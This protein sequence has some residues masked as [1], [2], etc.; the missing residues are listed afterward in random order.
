VGGSWVEKSRFSNSGERL[1]ANPCGFMPTRAGFGR[2][3]TL[4]VEMSKSVSIAA[5]ADAEED[6]DDHHPSSGIGRRIAQELG[7]FRA[8]AAGTAATHQAVG[9]VKRTRIG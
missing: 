9:C 2:R 5:G 8:L 6:F 4:S 1:D 7:H 3:Y